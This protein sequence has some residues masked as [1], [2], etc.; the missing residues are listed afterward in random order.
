MKSHSSLR[1]SESTHIEALSF[2]QPAKRLD[3]RTRPKVFTTDRSTPLDRAE[4]ARIIDKAVKARQAW[5]TTPHLPKLTRLHIDVL[6]SLLFSFHNSKTGKCVPSY[7]RIAERAMCSR[8]SVYNAIK[9]LEAHG[10]LTWAN[11]LKRIRAPALGLP[12]IGATRIRVVRWSNCY[13]FDKPEE[14]SKSKNQTGTIDQES[15]LLRTSSPP[16][17]PECP[18]PLA[19]ALK[20]LSEGV[21]G[22]K[23]P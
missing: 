18:I 16:T 10:L 4:K 11:R 3:R 12:G 1:Q 15:P 13:D 17:A 21:L 7:E 2:D 9:A 19:A 22:R 8:A 20:R 23:P 6:R 14:G 5:R